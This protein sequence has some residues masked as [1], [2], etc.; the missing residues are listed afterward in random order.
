[1]DKQEAQKIIKIL[2]ES[3]GGCEYCAADQIRRFC[4]AFPE[5]TPEAREAFL[6]KFD[7]DLDR[8]EQKE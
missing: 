4:E 6:E 2:L 3:D 1:M 5:Y 7:K 8:L